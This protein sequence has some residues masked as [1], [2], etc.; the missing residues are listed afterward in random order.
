MMYTRTKSE[1]RLL[2]NIDRLVI[3]LTFSCTLGPEQTAS[4]YML[5]PLNIG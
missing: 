5:M 3:S 1:D 2:R 4:G